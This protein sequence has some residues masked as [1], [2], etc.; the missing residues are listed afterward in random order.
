MGGRP[1][2]SWINRPVSKIIQH[3]FIFGTIWK[4]NYFTFGIRVFSFHRHSFNLFERD[5]SHA[6]HMDGAPSKKEM[7][8]V[9]IPCRRFVYVATSTCRF[10]ERP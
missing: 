10:G 3:R 6:K 2:N 4:R 9:F 5:F 8:Y 1:S 7:L